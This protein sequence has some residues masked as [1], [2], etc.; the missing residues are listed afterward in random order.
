MKMKSLTNKINTLKYAFTVTRKYNKKFA[1]MNFLISILM[2]ALP[3]VPTYFISKILDELAEVPNVKKIIT[4]AFFMISL[5]FIFYLM[6]N[7]LDIQ[8]NKLYHEVYWW[9][10]KI[11]MEKIVALDYELLENKKFQD[12]VKAYKNAFL[13]EGAVCASIWW[14]ITNIGS[15]LFSIFFSI[16]LVRKTIVQCLRIDNSSFITSVWPLVIL[17][18]TVVALSLI[19]AILGLKMQRE[20]AKLQVEINKNIGIYNYWL[21]FPKQYKNGKEIRIFKAKKLIS[22]LSDKQIKDST[23]FY[24]DK[25][26]KARMKTLT[27]NYVLE[28]LLMGSF[29]IFV[30]L[31]AYAEL[32]SVGDLS[33]FIGVA[34]SIS[35]AISMISMIPYLLGVECTTIG[36]LKNVLETKPIKK[37]GKLPIPKCIDDQ[38]DIEFKNVSFKYPNT[39]NLILKNLSI[40][41]IVGERLAIVGMNGSGKTTFIKLLCRLYDPTEGEILLNGINIKEYDITEYRK[42]FSVVFQ[43]FKLFAVPLCQNVATSMQYD[44]KRLWDT[45]NNAGVDKRVNELPFKEKTVLY[46]DFDNDGIE[47]SGGEAQKLALARALY[48]NAPFIILDEPTAA[49]DPISEYEIYQHFNSFVGEKTA[50]YI[51]HRLSSCRFCDKIAVFHKGEIIEVGNHDELISDERSKYYELW[52]SQAKYYIS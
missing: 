1:V 29:F 51:S 23:V 9:E 7:L 21:D 19:M 45:L 35:G 49:L 38:Y 47:I 12:S 27:V 34:T 33:M 30:A 2:A 6:E 37:S 36:Y 50:I 31:K 15:G 3:L 48:K 40:K 46:K 39:E 22:M 43:D 32:L 41:L 26:G 44:K 20:E 18:S 11:F 14:R 42:I 25:M 17:I 24:L 5:S 13:N 16:I 10:S 52:N 8:L 4:Y 28:A